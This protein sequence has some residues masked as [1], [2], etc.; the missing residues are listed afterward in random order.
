MVAAAI[1]IPLLFSRSCV[2]GLAYLLWLENQKKVLNAIH[3]GH[4]LDGV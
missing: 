2:A 3:R 1:K 4:M